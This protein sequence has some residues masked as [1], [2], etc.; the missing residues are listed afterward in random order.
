MTKC[1]N[2]PICNRLQNQLMQEKK[3]NHVICRLRVGP[4]GG[5]PWPRAWKCGPRPSVTVFHQTD[6]PAS[7]YHNYIYYSFKIFPIS[8]WLKPHAIHHNQQLLTKLGKSFVLSYCPDD[9]KS[10]NLSYWTNDIRSFVI[11]NQWCQKFCH[12]EPM[13]SKWHQ[14]CSTLQVIEPLTEKT[15]GRG[16]VIVGEQKN[17]E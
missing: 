14:K 1:L 12:I 3:N 8:D 16:C 5:K 4:Y 10:L 13:M 9:I 15:W 7:K 11:L 17:K 2:K 6:L